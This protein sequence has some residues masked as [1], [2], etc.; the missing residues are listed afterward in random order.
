MNTQTPS[1]ELIRLKKQ[2][3]KRFHPDNAVDKEDEIRLTRLMQEANAAFDARDEE[4]LRAVFAPPQPAPPQPPPNAW[5]PRTYPGA[6]QTTQAPPQAAA[7]PAQTGPAKMSTS[8]KAW[9]WITWGGWSV[10]CL[11]LNNGWMIVVGLF[12]SLFIANTLVKVQRSIERRFAKKTPPQWVGQAAPSGPRYPGWHPWF[13]GT[14]IICGLM[15]LAIGQIGKTGTTLNDT[16]TLT[17]IWYFLGGIPLAFFLAWYR[18]RIK[19]WLAAQHVAGL[20]GHLVKL[21]AAVAV[22][23][24]LT[25]IPIMATPIGVTSRT[26][27]SAGP[28]SMTSAPAANRI[29]TGD[30]EN[31][32]AQGI[33]RAVGSKFAFKDLG[34]PMPPKGAAVEMKF[35]I[36]PTGFANAASVVTSSGYRALDWSCTQAVDHVG[37][38]GILP[39]IANDGNIL[40]SYRCVYNEPDSITK[41]AVVPVASST[42]PPF[43]QK[44]GWYVESVKTKVAQK[45]YL[46]EVAESVPGGSTVYVQFLIDR[47]GHSSNVSLHTSS[48]WNSLDQSCL[49]AVKR[50]DTFGPLPSDYKEKSLNVLY[51]CT[52][53]GRSSISGEASGH[54]ASVLPESA[55]IAAKPL[56]SQEWH[57]TYTG[58]VHNNNMGLDADISVT[59]AKPINAAINGYFNVNPPLYGS[60]PLTG[61][62]VTS[63]AIE[64]HVVPAQRRGFELHFKGRRTG[65]GTIGGTY[66]VSSGQ[67]GTFT[68]HLKSTA[69]GSAQE[70]ESFDNGVSQEA[71]DTEL[72]EYDTK[73]RA[74]IQRF[75]ETW[76]TAL[77]LAPVG[78]FALADVTVRNDGTPGQATLVT[79][80][81]WQAIDSACVAAASQVATF[82]PLPAWYAGSRSVRYKCTVR[83][84]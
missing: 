2:A 26:S 59:L 25:M 14:W 41:I 51:H 24:L 40:V 6:Q 10:V 45:W 69:V 68:M 19:Q 38:F 30:A 62:N 74:L 9:F 4:R 20:Q 70:P 66:T 43:E 83:E 11:V 52:F 71:R 42:A 33:I 65:S 67:T 29:V 61:T 73:T 84:R 50:V 22:F 15:G 77:A 57:G 34:E 32:Y 76:P 8:F 27:S 1:P 72:S 81:R 36:G 13:W 46:K 44:F 82:G 47:N 60:G 79:T 37:N 49:N 28:A 18:D 75:F 54:G 63:D 17:G 5:G 35:Q 64:F 3:V 58:T 7:Q 56:V 48:S 21:A 23:I 78:T 80:S 55:S 16:A 31:G 53:P 12:A 39:A